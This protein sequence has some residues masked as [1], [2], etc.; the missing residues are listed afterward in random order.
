MNNIARGIVLALC[1]GL[2]YGL[3]P[4]FTRLAFQHG[5]PAMETALW[6]VVAL[7]LILLLIAA[8][9]RWRQGV[10]KPAR[11]LLALV[12]L[13]T[14]AISVGYLGAVQ[15]IP[16]TLAVIIF[17]TFPIVILLLAPFIERKRI[18]AVQ[19]GIGALAFGGLMIAVGPNTG[20]A[21]WRG[22]ALAGLAACGAATQFFSGR[23]IAPY[24]QPLQIGLI[25]HLVIVPVVAAI[26]LML[27]GEFKTALALDEISGVGKL[28]LGVVTLSYGAGFL[29]HMYALRSAPASSLAPYFNIE[30]VMS[31]AIAATVLAEPPSARELLGGA[32][33]LAAL[34][35]CGLAA[36]K[37]SRQSSGEQG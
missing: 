31:V 10:P 30:P 19:L 1:A 17:F 5:V 11:G 33:V 22:L 32:M 34:L 2:I 25:S 15:F 14:G 16:V 3:A 13:S 21:D 36:T 23:A 26:V 12:T 37:Q 28:A 8:M 18:S 35:A 6:R 29:C 7:L 27:G 24:M 20:G 9:G 4:P